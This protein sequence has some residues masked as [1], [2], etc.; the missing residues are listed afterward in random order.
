MLAA[1][2]LQGGLRTLETGARPSEPAPE[3]PADSCVET[4]SV[5]GIISGSWSGECVSGSRNGSYASY[6]IIT[7]AENSEVAITLESSVD[8]Y[9]YLRQGAGRD[10]SVL[11]E[12]DDILVGSDT[13][14]RLSVTLQPGDYT[15]EATTYYAQT[16]GDYTL[17]IAGLGSSE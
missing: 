7:L 1:T 16:R 5:D 9:L 4:I 2:S 10:G 13:N 14:S 6:Y 3:P 15:I 12:N 11:Y 8:T 17:T